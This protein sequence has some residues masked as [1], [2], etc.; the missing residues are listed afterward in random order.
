MA[1]VSQALQNLPPATQSALHKLGADLAVARL[2][3]RESL[4]SWSK[5]LGVSVRTLQ[6]LEA[7][8]EAQVSI[9]IVAKALWLIGRDG[10]IAQLAAPGEDGG[11]LEGSVQEAVR[12]GR[13]RAEASANAQLT[14]MERAKGPRKIP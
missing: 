12:L 9:G 1:K 6:R 11:A 8:D 5:R 7:G 10:Q 4:R 13:A 14:K 2:R 3:R